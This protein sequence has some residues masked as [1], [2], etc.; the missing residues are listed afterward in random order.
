M[1]TTEGK[2]FCKEHL[3]KL[4]PRPYQAVLIISGDGLMHEFVNSN[5]CGILP[6]CHIPG[7]SGNGFA[8]SVT[9]DAGEDCSA[10]VATFLAIKGRIKPYNIW[11]MEL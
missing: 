9:A 11:K 10:E 6:V 3:N 5:K 8:K 1:V 7:G 4:D 2:D